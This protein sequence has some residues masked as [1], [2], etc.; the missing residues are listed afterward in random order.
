MVGRG[1]RKPDG[2]NLQEDPGTL[3]KELALISGLADTSFPKGEV[4]TKPG[5]LHVKIPTENFR[6]LPLP[7]AGPQANMPWSRYTG[8]FPV[9]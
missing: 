4:S 2:Q 6:P 7:A 5:Q 1:D 3:P 9:M 8:Y